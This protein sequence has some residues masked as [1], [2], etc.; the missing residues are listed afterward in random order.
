MKH[1]F[2]DISLS[3]FFGAGNSGDTSALS[4]IFFGKCLK[5]KKEFRNAKEISEKNFCFLE[6][7]I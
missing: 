3:I 5:F 2:L 7:Y 4:V 1:G 6:N